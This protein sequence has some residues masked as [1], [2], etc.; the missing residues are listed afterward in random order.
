MHLHR[1]PSV[2]AWLRA[3]F[4]S[5]EGGSDVA[6]ERRLGRLFTLV[7][8]AAGAALRLWAIHAHPQIQGDSLL[9]G[10]IAVN[11]L[12]HGIYGHSVGHASGA[13]HH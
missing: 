13:Y 2:P 10:D 12:T 1:F 4:L 5:G 9:Y 11:W 6:P 7:V 8:L 3:G